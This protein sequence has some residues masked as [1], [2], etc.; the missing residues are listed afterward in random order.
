MIEPLL[1]DDAFL[2]DVEA[3]RQRKNGVHLWWLGQSGFLIHSGDACVLVDPYLSDSLTKKYAATDKPHVRMTERVIAPERL[4]FIDIVTSSHNH[5]DHLDASGF[6]FT[7]D[8]Q[9]VAYYADRA[10]EYGDIYVT[11]IAAWQPKRVTSMGDQ[12]K[13]FQIAT[14]EA[15]SW[16]S[17]D[18]TTIEGVLVKP[19]DFDPK[20]K[21]PLLVVIHGGPTG[22]DRTSVN[23][24]R[25]YP[26][27]R[28]VARGALVL[29]PNYRGSAGYGAKFRALNV[30]N[31]GVGDYA[32][33][34]SGVDALIA[35]GWVDRDRVID[36]TVTAIRRAGASIILTYW[37]A[38]LARRLA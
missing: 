13:P 19:A 20:K 23:A 31:L 24:D 11:P 3:A 18:G 28:F 7:G 35:K 26:I 9:Q 10:N 36:E 25:Y 17:S 14:R 27:E 8:Q 29:R 16:Q 38:E 1:K 33:V 22:I 15:V 12:L 37:A 34:I 21:Y 5:T 6:S 32:D 2:A 30:R 4:D